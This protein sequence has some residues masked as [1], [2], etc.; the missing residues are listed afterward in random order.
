MKQKLWIWKKTEMEYIAIV[1]WR[2]EGTQLCI[3]YIGALDD[4]PLP[5]SIGALVYMS[6]LRKVSGHC[7]A[8]WA[9]QC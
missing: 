7:V 1:S 3:I 9:Q 5:V 8:K 4:A 6:L 2:A